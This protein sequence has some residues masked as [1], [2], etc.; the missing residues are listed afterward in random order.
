MMGP[1]EPGPRWWR[2]R[3]PARRPRGEDIEHL[4][5]GAHTQIPLPPVE[6]GI[7]LRRLYAFQAQV[8]GVEVAL[9]DVHLTVEWSAFTDCR[10]TQAL[11][12]VRN[13]HGIAAQ[14]C[15]AISPSLYR[16]CTFERIRFKTLDGFTLGH[17]TFQNCTFLNCRWDGHFAT[18][19]WLVGNRFLGAMNGCVWFG[20]GP[21]GR[22]V[23]EG[24]DF[25]GTRFT[26]NVAFRGD[27]PLHTQRWPAGYQPLVDD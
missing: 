16:G 5:T 22:N 25:T 17:A 1:V 12:P 18:D 14:G 8:A 21:E 11:R 6:D 26:T 23:I 7:G 9:T 3:E 4:L 27:F 19:A 20:H 10:F 15:L 2:G 13:E 24:N